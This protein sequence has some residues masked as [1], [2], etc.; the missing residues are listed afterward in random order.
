MLITLDILLLIVNISVADA[1][2]YAAFFGIHIL[3]ADRVDGHEHRDKKKRWS[4]KQHINFFFHLQEIFD[5]SPTSEKRELENLF[6][7]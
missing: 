5:Q 6:C 7:C 3:R 1:A 2:F 4:A